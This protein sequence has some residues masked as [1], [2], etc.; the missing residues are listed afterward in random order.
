MKYS[1]VTTIRTIRGRPQRTPSSQLRKWIIKTHPSLVFISSRE[2][3]CFPG[4]CKGS[5]RRPLP[6]I[7][8]E[9]IAPLHRTCRSLQPVR[10]HPN[11]RSL[12]ERSRFRRR[13]LSPCPR[14]T[15]RSR[16]ELLIS[17]APLLLIE[18]SGLY[19]EISA[20]SIRFL[21]FWIFIQSSD[22]FQK[23]AWTE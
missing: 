12:C 19:E 21:R 11:S 6:K 18:L 4:R 9:T 22:A 23:P 3:C 5:G 20:L 13:F 10:L 17:L 14:A 15:A 8:F 1:P 16:A 7:P 2:G